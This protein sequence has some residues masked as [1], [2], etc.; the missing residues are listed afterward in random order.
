MDNKIKRP[1]FGQGKQ[2][3]ALTLLLLFVQGNKQTRE[4]ERYR[5][6]RDS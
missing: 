6:L 3:E 1:L 4:K 2:A 5:T